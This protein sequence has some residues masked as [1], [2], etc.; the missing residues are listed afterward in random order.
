MGDCLHVLKPQHIKSSHL[1]YYYLSL[2][3]NV[4]KVESIMSYTISIQSSLSRCSRASWTKSLCKS[5]KLQQKQWMHSNT[6]WQLKPIFPPVEN[7]QEV[8]YIGRYDSSNARNMTLTSCD[9]AMRNHHQ[10]INLSC[11][12]AIQETTNI[13]VIVNA[14]VVDLARVESL[15]DVRACELGGPKTSSGAAPRTWSWGRRGTGPPTINTWWGSEST[16]WT[17]LRYKFDQYYCNGK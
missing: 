11:W 8:L 1:W 17:F 14:I 10:A 5:I 2:E 15:D 12:M 9:L 3:L 7:D 6:I 13:C 4:H 16:S